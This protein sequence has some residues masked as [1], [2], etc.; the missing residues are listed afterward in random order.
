MAATNLRSLTK[1]MPAS[2]LRDV[3][4]EVKI[5]PAELECLRELCRFGETSKKIAKGLGISERMAK[6]YINSLLLKTGMENRTLLALWAQRK[7]L[8]D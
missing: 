2:P 3:T 7:G 1:L 5:T 8:V 6:F 4:F